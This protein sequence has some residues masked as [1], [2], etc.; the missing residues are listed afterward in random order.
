MEALQQIRLWMRGDPETSTISIKDVHHWMVQVHSSYDIPSKDQVSF[1]LDVLT[2]FVFK[3]QANV[4][5]SYTM[6]ILERCFIIMIAAEYNTLL[7]TFISVF[8]R[9]ILLRYAI[10]ERN[11]GILMQAIDFRLDP[12]DT[13]HSI[14]AKD[15]GVDALARISNIYITPYIEGETSDRIANLRSQSLSNLKW[16][17]AN[18][19]LWRK[20]PIFPQIGKFPLFTQ[21]PLFYLT[22]HDCNV[23]DHMCEQARLYRNLL[24]GWYSHVV[25]EY[26]QPHRTLRTGKKRR[27]GFL[28]RSL[29]GH[30]V[31]RVSYGLIEQLSKTGQFDIYIYADNFDN[32]VIGERLKTVAKKVTYMEHQLGLI[33][34]TLKDDMLDI[35]VLLDPLQDTL[36]YIVS[37]YRCAPVQLT[38]W[39]HPGT[40]GLDTIDYYVTSK[41]F[42]DDPA[43]YRE[44]LIA[45]DSLSIYYN[46]INELVNPYEEEKFDLIPY[47]ENKGGVPFARQII[48]LP[49]EGRIY[50]IVGPIFKLSVEFDDVV[51]QIIKNDPGAYI[52]MFRGDQDVMLM[53]F[54]KRLEAKLTES[55]MDRILIISKRLELL[56]FSFYVYACNVILDSFPFGGLISSYDTFSVGRCMVALPCKRLGKFTTGLYEYMDQPELTEHLV[57]KDVDDYVAKAIRVANDTSHRQKLEALIIKGMQR[58]HYDRASVDEWATFLQTVEKK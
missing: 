12:K 58:I 13:L 57:A 52:S 53:S 21:L 25:L 6:D 50:G 5:C 33:V 20:H 44:S 54:V 29:R 22:Y 45:F 35:L 47:I 3:K 51:V 17:N 10:I 11:G 48:N 19:E 30:S 49:L 42:K 14:R 32:S 27:V 8:S 24:N 9:W 39:G 55:E 2:F 40:T 37:Q 28:S 38:T 31:G 7:S 46:H 18:I 23:Q 26:A 1:C 43:H 4:D 34:K 36:T 15:V 16:L 41:L 56:E